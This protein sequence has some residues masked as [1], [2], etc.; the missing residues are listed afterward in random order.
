MSEAILTMYSDP[1]RAKRNLRGRR[2]AA[3][4]MRQEARLGSKVNV[5]ESALNL[6]SCIVPK[7]LSGT[8]QNGAWV[9]LRICHFRSEDFEPTGEKPTPNL[10]SSLTWN[11]ISL[12]PCPM[13]GRPTARN[14]VGGAGMGGRRKQRPCCN[15]ADRGCGSPTLP[16]PKGSR[17]PTGLSSRENLQNPRTGGQANDSHHDG[18]CGLRR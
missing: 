16:R 2:E 7:M 12:Y 17:L 14:A 15:G 1:E 6:V 8:D 5:C 4:I 18:W 11:T 13:M 9:G 3:S 10:P